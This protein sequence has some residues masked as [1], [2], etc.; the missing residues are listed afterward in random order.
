MRFVLAGLLFSSLYV[1]LTPLGVRAQSA[2][3][4]QQRVAYEM[5]IRLSPENH[6]LQGTQRLTYWNESPDTLDRVF[7]HLYFNAFN[8]RSMM[9]ERNRELPDP[10]ARVV[11]R[12]FNLTPEQ[13]GWHRVLSLTQDGVPVEFHVTDT[14]MEVTL[15]APLAPGESSVFEM[16][17]ESQVPLQTRRSGRDSREGVDYSMAQWYPKMAA[18]DHLGWHAEPY[19]GREFYAPFGTFDV[20]LT[21]PSR[22]VVAATGV[23]QN[24]GEVGHGYDEA[25][26]AGRTLSGPARSAT[27]AVPDSITYHFFAE[28][29]HDF[30]WGADPHYI[31]E[32]VAVQG[33]YPGEPDR[34]LP[35]HLFYLPDVAERWEQ[36]GLWMQ[37]LTEYFNAAYG[38][39]PY[40]Q[41]S[42]VQ[43]G[44]GGMEYPML[45]LITGNRPPLSLL[46]VTAHEYAHMWWYGMLGFNETRYSWMDEGLTSFATTE[47]VNYVT[48]RLAAMAGTGPEPPSPLVQPAR[49]SHE[50]ALI[51]VLRAERLGVREQLNQAADWYLTNSG[52]SAAAYSGGQVLIDLLGYVVSD[53]VRDEILREFVR[54]YTF[55]HPY[56][57]DFLAVAQDVSGLDLKWLFEQWLDRV[58]RTDYAVQGLRSTRAGTGFRTVVEL[59][60]RGDMVLPI[61]LRLTLDDGSTQWVNIPLMVMH[62][63]KPVPEDWLVAE[64]WPWTSPAYTLSLNTPQRIVRV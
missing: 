13:E 34:V 6:R 56:P 42:V 49:A 47:S 2:P 4:W 32:R 55:Q 58:L 14:V 45:T 27:G 54:R 17:F 37:L 21:V 33:A 39:Y 10:D 52:F 46:G 64:G 38:P 5:D 19:V 51:N 12:I 28:D 48:Q 24:P 43:G 59:E 63:H 16:A 35:V 18:Y 9:A 23:L 25:V 30:A 8:P 20:R 50:P 44:D 40:P 15:A 29:V 57:D 1:V 53:P 11:P 3:G 36:L 61:D 60:R 7:Y 26:D 31:H 62:G 41:F 22:Y